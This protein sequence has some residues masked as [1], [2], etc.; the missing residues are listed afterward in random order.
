MKSNEQFLADADTIDIRNIV[1]I[2]RRRLK[3]LGLAVSLILSV[4]FL[5]LAQATPLYTARALILIDTTQ[6]NLLQPGQEPVLN[7]SLVASIID[8]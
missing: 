4:A 3:L 8:S 5:Y 1:S 7:S 2:L 6:K